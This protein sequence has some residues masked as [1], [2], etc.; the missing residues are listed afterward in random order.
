M[1][2]VDLK[3]MKGKIQFVEHFAD[4]EAE[5]VAFLPDL[6][7]KLVERFPDEPGKWQ[8]VTSFPDIKIKLV[9]NFGDFK[10]Q[11]VENSNGIY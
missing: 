9:E 4:F 7:V 10:I 3:Q 5:I 11:F 8:I 1:K 6:K 2:T